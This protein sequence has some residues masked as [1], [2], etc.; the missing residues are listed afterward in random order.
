MRRDIIAVTL[1][2]A[3][4]GCSY[5]PQAHDPP[6]TVGSVL[7]RRYEGEV[8][9]RA[10]PELK[11]IDF[12][13]NGYWTVH[14]DLQDVDRKLSIPYVGTFATDTGRRLYDLF[15]EQRTRV[16]KGQMCDGRLTLEGIV[17]NGKFVKVE[18]VELNS[19]QGY[20]AHGAEPQG[21]Q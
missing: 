2:A 4:G 12:P 6:K 13:R 10:M 5:F 14:V 19:P 16:F 3:L 8:T 9:I 1:A 17:I 15:R 7:A 18:E 11:S 20:S 21:P